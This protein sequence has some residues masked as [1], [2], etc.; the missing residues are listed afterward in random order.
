M[1]ELVGIKVDRKEQRGIVARKALKVLEEF[2]TKEMF[3]E[4]KRITFDERPIKE[5]GRIVGYL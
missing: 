5:N 4:C 2:E 3:K 1:G